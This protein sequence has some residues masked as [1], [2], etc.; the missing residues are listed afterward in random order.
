MYTYILIVRCTVRESELQ[1]CHVLVE[2][3]FLNNQPIE[4]YV[5]YI[6]YFTISR[7]AFSLGPVTS[8]EGKRFL[9][10]IVDTGY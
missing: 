4:T 5:A 3:L 1:S 6:H 9:L 8:Y 7:T 2:V 10:A